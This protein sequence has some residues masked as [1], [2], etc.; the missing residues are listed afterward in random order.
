M[1]SALREFLKC[2]EDDLERM[3]RRG[4]KLVEDKYASTTVS[5]QFIEMYENLIK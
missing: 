3:G 1:I 2:S 5:K 4:K